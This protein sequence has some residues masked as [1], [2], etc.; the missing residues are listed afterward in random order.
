M[1]EKFIIIDKCNIGVSSATRSVLQ[2]S[3]GD[4]CATVLFDDLEIGCEVYFTQGRRAPL[5]QEYQD[6]EF[7]YS[8]RR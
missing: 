8:W 5:H 7:K 1:K 6:G 2:D 4:L 3:N